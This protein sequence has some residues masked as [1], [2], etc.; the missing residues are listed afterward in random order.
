MAG[1]LPTGGGGGGLP[2]PRPPFGLGSGHTH[3]VLLFND[4][5]H[6]A[7]AMKLYNKAIA[8]MDTK[9]DGHANN[10]AV[11]LANVRDRVH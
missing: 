4:P 9:L 2:L 5:I 11:F 6:G 10:L 8:P 7:T 3:N 1:V